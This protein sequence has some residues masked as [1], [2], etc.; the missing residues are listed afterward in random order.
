MARFSSPFVATR[1]PLS[2][3]AGWLWT[4][5]AL[6]I[7]A[8]ILWRAFSGPP[9]QAW[10]LAAGAVALAAVGLI[11]R[12]PDWGVLALIVAVYWNVSD[13]LTQNTGFTWLLSALLLCTVAAWALHRG[14]GRDSAPLA[15]PW[16]APVLVW[17]AAQAIAGWLG[18]NHP[19]SWAAMVGYAKAMVILY[20]VA[21]LLRSPRR[22]RAGVRALLVAVLLLTGPVLIQ[23]LTGTGSDFWGFAAR[24][25]AEIAPGRMGWRPGGSLGDPNF[26]AMV[27]VAT[28]PLALMELLEDQPWPARLL[29]GA[30]A[31]AALA[32]SSLS[33]SRASLLGVLFVFACFALWHRRRKWVLA[34]GAAALVALFAVMPASY[35]ARVLSLSQ[36]TQWNAP[37]QS[38]AD[39]SFRGRRAEWLAGLLMWRDHPVWGVGTGSYADAY[40]TYSAWVGLDPRGEMRDPHSLYIEILADSGTVGLAAFLLLVGCVLFGL[41]RARLRLLRLAPAP[42]SL[43]RPD[44]HWRALAGTVQAIAWSILTYLLLSLFLHS[45]FTRHFYLLVALGAAALV[46]ARHAR[47]AAPPWDPSSP[48]PLDLASARTPRLTPAGAPFSPPPSECAFVP[49]VL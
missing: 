41:R 37:Q 49:R 20:L 22:L 19:D 16:L 46:V 7:A 6:L 34:G 38:I 33:Y 29:G 43:A 26:F 45:A 10:P 36:V 14:L 9:Q 30:A 11:L 17:G 24:E 2:P 15:W 31:A 18:G 1:P 39:S 35:R 27:L 12:R 32:A 25:Y 40:E 3:L 13:V 21:N 23:S 47:P 28:L 5:L 4:T 48:L 44:P 8:P 42:A